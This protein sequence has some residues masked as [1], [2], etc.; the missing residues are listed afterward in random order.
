MDNN[1]TKT[2]LKTEELEKRVEELENFWRHAVAD[3]RNLQKRVEE[4]KLGWKDFANESLLKKLLPVFDNL[5]RVSAHIKDHGLELTLKDFKQVLKNEG[6]EEL[7]SDG[8]IFDPLTM[9]A[10]EVVEGEKN[11][12]IETILS[13]Y[14]LQQKLLRPARVKVGGGKLEDT[15]NASE[16]PAEKA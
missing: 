1:D 10:I 2:D 8:E 11:K 5:Q 4:E 6:V 9:E 14:L 16:E 12:V 7:K 3:Y 13:G 15:K